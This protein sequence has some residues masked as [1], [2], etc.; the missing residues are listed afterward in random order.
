MHVKYIGAHDAVLVPEVGAEV[1]NGETVEVPEDIGR[2]LIHQGAEV[3]SLGRAKG[4]GSEWE[5][6]KSPAKPQP[7]TRD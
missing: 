5:E 6:A 7:D 4:P 1:A 3:D 2:R